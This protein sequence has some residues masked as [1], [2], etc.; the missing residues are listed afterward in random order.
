M[1]WKITKNHIGSRK[2]QT[3]G[4][5]KATKGKKL[6]KFRMFDDDGNLYYEGLSTCNSSFAPLDDYGMPNAGCTEIRYF[7]SG[8]WETL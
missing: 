6:Y 8:R 5:K 3:V 7:E 2:M 1:A 4:F